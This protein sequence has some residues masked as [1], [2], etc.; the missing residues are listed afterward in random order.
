MKRFTDAGRKAL[1]GDNLYVAL[2]LALTLPDICGSME[3]PGP[4]KSQKRYE[5]WFTKWLA[6]TYCPHGSTVKL[7]AHDCFQLRCSLIHSGSSD[8]DA[9]KVQDIE[10]IKFF[11]NTVRAHLNYAGGNKVN[12][13]LQQTILQL[14]TEAFCN[15]VFDAVDKWDVAIAADATIQK[16][17][18]KL[19]TIHS[20]GAS[21]GGV[22]FGSGSS[23]TDPVKPSRQQ[24]R[25]QERQARKQ[26]K[27]SE[28]DASKKSEPRK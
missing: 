16:E 22:H 5:A 9:K 26:Q 6:P 28:R 8:I 1:R 2:S 12:G 4:G 7:T 18:A 25:H 21:V 13:V 23:R 19:L 14:N 3:D 11:D 17:K 20:S 27:Q 10:S 24:R 15:D